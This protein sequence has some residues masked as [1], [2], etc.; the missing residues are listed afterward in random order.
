[1]NVCVPE[2]A[3]QSPHITTIA[4]FACVV[5]SDTDGLPLDPVAILLAPTPS[6][7]ENRIIL[8]P[9]YSD[10]GYVTVTVKFSFVDATY[11]EARA[12]TQ[13][14]FTVGLICR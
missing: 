10:A 5:V 4:L 11:V 7:P 12:E 13:S 14:A 8:P 3:F 2:T 6:L 1:V 9:K